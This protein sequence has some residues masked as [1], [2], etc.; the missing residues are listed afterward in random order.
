VIISGD[1]TKDGEKLDH[2][3][4]ARYLRR[5]AD[6]GKRIYVVP[7]NHDVL[8]PDAQSYD[9]DTTRPGD[10]VTPEDFAQ[11]YADFGYG[12][13][14]DRDPASL[15]Y[16]TEPKHG[17]WLLA[18]SSVDYDGNL[19]NTLAWIEAALKRAQAQGKAVIAMEHH[20]VVEHWKGQARYHPDYL[21][22][23]Y[24]KAGELFAKYG[25]RLVFTGHYHADDIAMRRYGDHGPANLGEARL[26]GRRALA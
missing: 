25:A 8:N 22:R 4:L 6:S 23:D 11:I 15:S 2:Q 24:A 13:A 9:R 18:L 5:I 7:G 12:E 10:C 1:L 26:R 16:L 3:I 14:L 19:V 21:V 17:L 20:G